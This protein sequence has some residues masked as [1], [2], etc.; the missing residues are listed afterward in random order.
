MPEASPQPSDKLLL[1]R[2]IEAHGLKGEVKIAAFT[3]DPADIAAYGELETGGSGRIEIYAVRPFK[4]NVVIAKVR[5]IKDRSAAEALRGMELCLARERLPETEDE[6]F[7][8][9]D[10]LGLAVRDARGQLAGAVIAV[11]NFGAGD[12]L[13]IKLAG[14]RKSEI[15]PFNKETVPELNLKERWLRLAFAIRELGEVGDDG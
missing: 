14:T 4:G 10:L 11:H 2:V 7:Y 6:E 3:Q 12:L 5:G 13:E 1:G 9:A 15:V 8:H